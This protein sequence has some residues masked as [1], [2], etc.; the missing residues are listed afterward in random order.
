MM[1]LWLSTSNYGTINQQKSIFMSTVKNVCFKT[2]VY[3]Q[4]STSFDRIKIYTMI[5]KLSG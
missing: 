1:Q 2:I 4:I 5:L 3:H